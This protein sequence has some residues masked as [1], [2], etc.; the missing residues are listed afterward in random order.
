[1]TTNAR[2]WNSIDKVKHLGKDG[3]QHF[4]SSKPPL[5]ATLYAGLYQAIYSSTGL[6]LTEEP[7]VV[8]RMIVALGI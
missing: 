1:M 2:P 4:Y 8:G 6:L 3:K 5:L 7:F